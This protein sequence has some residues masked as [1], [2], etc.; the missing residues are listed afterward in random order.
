MKALKFV[1]NGEEQEIVSNEQELHPICKISISFEPTLSWT[2]VEWEYVDGAIVIL[3]WDWRYVVLE[4]GILDVTV[5]SETRTLQVF[6]KQNAELVLDEDIVTWLLKLDKSQYEWV[7]DILFH[8]EWWE[9]QVG[10]V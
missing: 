8:W 1:I 10:E 9:W 2:I 3:D 7:D 4:E 5:W 6:P